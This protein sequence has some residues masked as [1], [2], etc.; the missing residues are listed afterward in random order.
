MCSATER[1]S[2]E[3][4]WARFILCT[5]KKTAL[6]YSSLSLLPFR[7]WPATYTSQLSMTLQTPSM[8]ATRL[9][10]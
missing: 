10:R 1:N 7:P 5:D 3:L 6:C 4:L 9:H 8:P 2:C